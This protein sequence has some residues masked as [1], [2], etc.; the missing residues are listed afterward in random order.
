M[1]YTGRRDDYEDM[2]AARDPD[3]D[4]DDEPAEWEEEDD[5]VAPGAEDE[6]DESLADDYDE[7]DF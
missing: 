2:P 5:E 7:L 1:T 4:I 3:D 6:D